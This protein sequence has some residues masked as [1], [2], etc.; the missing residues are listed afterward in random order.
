MKTQY[1][2]LG[3]KGASAGRGVPE[4]R[5]RQDLKP[6]MMAGWR[7]GAGGLLERPPG[8]GAWASG[9]RMGCGH[10]R[11][12]S[13]TTQPA[14]QTRPTAQAGLGGWAVSWEE[15]STLLSCPAVGPAVTSSTGHWRHGP[16]QRPGLSTPRRV[17][18]PA[19]AERL[20]E[21]V[22]PRPF[23][24][25]APLPRAPHPVALPSTGEALEAPT[26][27]MQG[28]AGRAGHSRGQR[29]PGPYHRA[30]FRRAGAGCG[31]GLGSLV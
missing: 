5:R 28:R 27:H 12:A 26:A 16:Q 14:P 30:H 6:R 4:P 29:C 10:G 22:W 23:P 25:R 24:V 13:P 15:G 18:A 11:P 20:S 7:G 9:S 17:R 31:A 1:R 19:F 3:D 21:R 8:A 2:T